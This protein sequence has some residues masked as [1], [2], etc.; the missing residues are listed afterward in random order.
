MIVEVRKTLIH[1]VPQK[2]STHHY[3]EP[4]KRLVEHYKS[5]RRWDVGWADDCVGERR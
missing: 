5:S 1:A 4:E 2:T 3:S